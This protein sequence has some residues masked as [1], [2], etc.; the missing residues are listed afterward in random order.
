MACVLNI[1]K[2]NKFNNRVFFR[3]ANATNKRITDNRAT[4]AIGSRILT[5]DI[6]TKQ[7]LKYLFNAS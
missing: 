1:I 2:S 6:F 7:I 4:K 5:P 3:T